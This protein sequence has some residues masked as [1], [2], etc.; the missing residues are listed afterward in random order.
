MFTFDGTGKDDVIDEA[1]ECKYWRSEHTGTLW[2]T[3]CSLTSTLDSK[4]GRHVD[5]EEV[6]LQELV[7]VLGITKLQNKTLKAC[8]G[9]KT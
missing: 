4:T 6:L 8:N 5:M 2:V 1:Q 7:D 9:E 3:M